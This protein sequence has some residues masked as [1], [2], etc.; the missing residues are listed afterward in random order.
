MKKTIRLALAAILTLGIA[1][2]SSGSAA[3]TSEAPAADAAEDKVITVGVNP[4]PHSE[5]ME[6]A[7]KAALAEE[8]WELNVVVFEDYVLPNTSL[9]EGELDANYF[10]TLGYMKD[11]NESRGLHLVAVAG[12]H[13]EPMG[14]YSEKYTDYKDIPDGASIAVPNDTDNES[15]ALDL[16]IAKGLLNNP[17]G[18]TN[19]YV[20]DTDFNGNDA[21]NPH[22]Y[23]IVLIEAASLPIN[24][25][26]V[27]AAVINGN[28][29]LGADLPAKHPALFIEEFDEETAVRRTNFLVVKEGSENSDKIA[30]LIKATQSETV[31]KFIDDTYKGAVITS[32]VEAE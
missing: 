8:G 5:I 28:Y 9:E 18:R 3:A 32:F 22:G 31:Q 25:P 16:L 21:T 30:A 23:N 15:R 10:Q 24:L 17:E 14:L 27:D 13:I 1:G 29:A 20:A 7:V 19:E 4:V 6:N 11:Q 12:V 26:D 2:C